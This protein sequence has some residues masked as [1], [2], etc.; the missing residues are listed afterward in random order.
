MAFLS[1]GLVRGGDTFN[2]LGIQDSAAGGPPSAHT[3]RVTTPGQVGPSPSAG[4]GGV[5]CCTSQSKTLEQ[6]GTWNRSKRGG[7]PKDP[8]RRGLYQNL[9]WSRTK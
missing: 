6:G 9:E 8:D 5:Q 3:A 1:H 2:S 7:Q 4:V